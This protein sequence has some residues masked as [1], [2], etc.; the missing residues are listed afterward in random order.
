MEERKASFMG[1]ITCEH[2]VAVREEA[3][4]IKNGNNPIMLSCYPYSDQSL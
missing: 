3:H 4:Y 1:I 2:I